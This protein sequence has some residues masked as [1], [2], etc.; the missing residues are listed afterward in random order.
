MGVL[1]VP[2]LASCATPPAVTGEFIGKDGRIR[3]HPNGRF[4]IVVEP[5]T[6]K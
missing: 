2:F 1:T 4:E 6:T 3:V 5:R